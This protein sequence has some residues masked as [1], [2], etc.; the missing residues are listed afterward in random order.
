MIGIAILVVTGG[1]L[2]WRF[3]PELGL[4]NRNSSTAESISFA[5]A[6]ADFSGSEMMPAQQTIPTGEAIGDGK[7]TNVLRFWA[8]NEPEF[9]RMLEENARI[10]RRQVV[11]WHATAISALERSRAAGESLRQIFLPGLDGRVITFEITQSEVEPS[12]TSGILSGRVA[13]FPDSMVRL[14]FSGDQE[15]FTVALPSKNLFLAAETRG[16]GDI[17]LKSIDPE[18]YTAFHGA[19]R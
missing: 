7:G 5:G 1:L 17:I 4:R 13:G 12:G 18:A 10:K 6:A 15:V 8:R 2:A 14:R 19:V 16:D 3:G 9:Q 11:Q